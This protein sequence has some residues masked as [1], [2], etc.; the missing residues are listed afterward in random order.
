[1]RIVAITLFFFCF[2]LFSAAQKIIEFPEVAEQSHQELSI[3]KI[4]LYN[5]ST[6]FDLSVENK[7]DQGGWFC[8]DKNISMEIS[9]DHKRYTLVNSLGIPTCPSVHNFKRSGE[10]LN[11]SLVFQGIPL[12]TKLLNLT[13][14]CD[15]S[16]FFFH[17]II[18]DEKLNR[19]IKLY[20]RG[21][22]L[23][24]ANNSADALACFRK[25]VEQLPASPTHVYGY[26]Y[27]NLIKI[28]H[29]RGDKTNVRYWYDQLEKS[30]LPD[31]QYFIDS[32]QKDGITAK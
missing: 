21:T 31:K 28:Y 2:S 9:S 11:F 12:G 24:K 29:A 14:N 3:V 25:V 20:N 15:N 7:L 8:A 17:E 22:E 6:V 32:L 10:K 23:Y 5:D 30:N 18:L 1:M 19:D 13:E 26:A 16:C 27:F 4:S